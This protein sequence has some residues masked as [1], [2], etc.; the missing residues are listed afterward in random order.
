M[1]VYIRKKFL[2]P[3]LAFCLLAGSLLSACTKEVTP[4]PGAERGNMFFYNAS[5]ALTG[6]V[7]SPT[8]RRVNFILMDS[9]DSNY[10]WDADRVSKHPYFE[11]GKIVSFP[12]MVN[13]WATYWP[14]L[15]G[16]HTLRLLDSSGTVLLTDSVNLDKQN[17]AQVFYTDSCGYFRSV[18]TTDPFMSKEKQIGMR[19][20]NLSPGND[21]YFLTINKKIPAEL[22][23]ATHYGDHTGYIAMNSDRQDTLAIKVFSV[24]DSTNA[25]SRVSL[26]V[27]PGHA[28]TLLMSGYPENHPASYKDPRTGR[29][30]SLQ[31]TFVI[32][33]LKNY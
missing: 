26:I 14:V 30:I 10:V 24:S 15:T 13:G 22:P 33:A 7:A 2:Q 28:Y 32:Q 23:A 12:E 1:I 31:T 6:Q 3:L 21:K 18:V 16:P 5:V 8:R 19:L 17:A 29:I 11:G 27:T 20:I 9:Q 4:L 25:M